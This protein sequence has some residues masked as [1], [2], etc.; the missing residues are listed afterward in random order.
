MKY[1]VPVL[2]TFGW[3]EPVKSMAINS[4]PG[5]PTKGDRYIVPLNVVPADVWDDHSND[6]AWFDGNEWK[7]D[8]PEAG[9]STFVENQLLAFTYNGTEWGVAEAGA[10]V[11][12]ELFVD[13]NRTDTYPANGSR[14]LPYK[15]VMDAIN[16]VSG[17]GDNTYDKAYSIYLM[18]GVYD[19]NVTFES[20]T[21]VN[22]TLKG[23]S[24][25]SVTIRPAA[26]NALQSNANNGML[27][28]LVVEN[29][30]VDAPI[31][32]AGDTN[33]TNFG[34]FLGFD[35][36]LVTENAPMDISN[37]QSVHIL[38]DSYVHADVSF[39]NIGLTA[40]S[41]DAGLLPGKS[42]TMKTLPGSNMPAGITEPKL[43]MYDNVIQRDITWDTTGGGTADV[44]IVSAVL[45]AAEDNNVIIP[46]GITYTAIN[47]TLQGNYTYNG[48]LK[49]RGSFV[50]GTL[51][52]N[53]TGNLS[54]KVQSADMMSLG[55]PPDGA[56]SDGLVDLAD[57]STV[58]YAV[59]EFNE[60]LKDLAPPQAD[61]LTGVNLDNNR[62]LRT[63][64]VPSG[65]SGSWYD[66]KG[67]SPGDQLTNVITNN[68]LTLAT[69]VGAPDSWN[70]PGTV[71]VEP[72]TTNSAN[73]RKGDEGLLKAKH[74]IGAGAFDVV[75]NLDIDA[76]FKENPP[77]SSPPRPY[78]QDLTTWDAQG[79]GDP[80]ADAQVTFT[81]GKGS[82]QIT[83][84]RWFNDFNKWQKMNAQLN[85]S[86]LDPGFNKFSLLHDLAQDEE[87]AETEIYYADN[88]DVMVFSAAPTVIEN[89][90]S[91]T[92]YVSG[93]RYYSTG[94][95]FD[96]NYAGDNVFSNI[97][98]SSRCSMFRFDGRGANNDKQPASPPAVT[99]TFTISE[100]VA[101]DRG[102]FYTNNATLEANFYHPYK[103]SIQQ[104]T[105]NESRLI[106]TYADNRSTDLLEYFTDEDYRMDDAAFDSVPASLTGN[107]DST[108]LVPAGKA[109]IMPSGSGP[110]LR[111][112]NADLSGTLPAG[113]PN[114]SGRNGAEVYVRGFKSAAANSGCTIELRGLTSSDVGIKGSGSVNVEVKLPGLTGWLDAGKAFN[115]S[116]FTGADGDGC[117]TA[118]SGDDWTLTFGTFSTAGCGGVIIVRI[119]FNDGSN[120]ITRMTVTNF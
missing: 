102:N 15:S 21:L 69:G 6:I 97:Y 120:G 98:H 49:L 23:S 82:L 66:A 68:S 14:S 81:N 95:T 43:Y 27:R 59:D 91:S 12:T 34:G 58:V 113:N 114:Y 10:V 84:V 53:S 24:R 70:P 118:V 36:V 9:W 17:Y 13:N 87:S 116:Q 108:Q 100:T 16:A 47:S 85:I 107:W 86:N 74:Q 80:C 33:G 83:D 78:V 109:V 111:A 117:Q 72:A 42:F 119:T 35:D 79:A 55:L 44:Q 22:L 4:A 104:D 110:V 29:L 5:A 2:E 39:S 20:T 8:T 25:D 30:A 105:A 112:G 99:D 93:V 50:T 19:E 61:P 52:P 26:G 94:D 1:R 57:D 88:A 45:G 7:F 71:P 67:L 62:T 40:L 3:Q 77:G 37:A 63:G 38:G 96:V 31:V 73:F 41:N 101:V 65:M 11:T 64:R 28:K 60:I 92:K 115:S 56:L 18:P 48:D 103:A 51:D 75:A 90:L 106:N 32:M 46:P 76:N 54:M 89:T